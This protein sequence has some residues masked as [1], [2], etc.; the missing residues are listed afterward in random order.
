MD[1]SWFLL[2]KCS[3][4]YSKSDLQV[5]SGL[6][7]TVGIENVPLNVHL[8]FYS[9]FTWEDK[10]DK[11]H[12]TVCLYDQ[13]YCRKTSTWECFGMAEVFGFLKRIE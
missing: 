5:Q 1:R 8:S 3:K 11:Y 9:F 7:F 6:R 10:V 4:I 13:N 2:C 12:M